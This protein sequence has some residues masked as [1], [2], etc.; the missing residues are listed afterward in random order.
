VTGGWTSEDA[1]IL[2][3]LAWRICYATTAKHE[4][5]LA[6]KV[7]HWPRRVFVPSQRWVANLNL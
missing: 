6:M 5:R 4:I 3:N 2:K 1:K 7:A